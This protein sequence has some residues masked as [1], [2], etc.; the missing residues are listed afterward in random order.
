MPV[1]H[2]GEHATWGITIAAERRPEILDHDRKSRPKIEPRGKRDQAI[3]LAIIEAPG[4]EGGVWLYEGNCRRIVVIELNFQLDWIS[5]QVDKPTC[6]TMFRKRGR[7]A[8]IVD[9]QTG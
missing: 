7:G 9:D 8:V 2:G 5:L 1:S 4:K 6:C 3:R